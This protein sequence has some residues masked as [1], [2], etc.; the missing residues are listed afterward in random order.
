MQPY[1]R[2]S[3]MDSSRPSLTRRPTLPSPQNGTRT[4]SAPLSNKSYTT[5]TPSMNHPQATSSTMGRSA[6]STS[7]SVADYIR[8]PSGSISMTTEWCPGITRL[9]G[10]TSSPTLLTYMQQLT[11]V[12][13][14]PLNPY[15]CGSIT[16]S[17]DPEATS[18]SSS[19]PLP[20]QT[21]GAL[22]ERLHITARS[23]TTL[24]PLQHVL[25]N[26]NETSTPRRPVLHH[27]SCAS[28]SLRPPNRLSP[29]AM[30]HKNLELCDW[31]GG[32]L[33][34]RHTTSMS[35]DVH[36]RGRVMLLALGQC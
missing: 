3:P 16:Y 20:T 30:Y 24:C 2:V 15:P 13:T 10:P 17:P 23:T 33:L 26:T 29:F 22:H 7:P 12:S 1:S 19:K 11:T 21:T 14:H 34:A 25:K 35:K 36:C 27:V 28:C 8:R 31:V 9:R 18:N 4:V 5:R 6:T 32:V